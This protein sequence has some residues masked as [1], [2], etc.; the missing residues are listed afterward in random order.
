MA[1][2]AWTGIETRNQIR[3]AS[4]RAVRV[5]ELRGTIAYLDEWL[6]MSA[7]MAASSGERLWAERFEEA[8]PKLDAA[9]AEAA[10]LATP[11]VRAA[12][13]RT[14]DEAHRDLVLM[15]RRALKL[16]A[17]GDLAAARALLGGPEFAYLKDVYASGIEEFGVDL[18]TLAT[19]RAS[20]LNDRAW[21]E[22]AGLGL[23][24]V[25]LVSTAL[26][27]RTQSRLRRAAART[28][29]M[30]RTDA[31]TDLPN[32]RRFYEELEAALA[33]KPA[34]CVGY[35]L[36][37]IDLDR[38][39][40]ANDAYGH[41]AGDELLRLV[42]ARLKTIVRIGDLIARLSGDEFAIVLPLAEDQSQTSNDPAQVA[43]RVLSVL[44]EPFGLGAG[45]LAQIA[46]SV[47][48]A[49]AQPEDDRSGELMHRAEVALY[50]AKADG[51][52]CVRYFEPTMDDHV[53]ARALL[54]SELRQAVADDT[55]VPYF[56][57]LIEIQSGRLIGV[58]MLARWPHPHRGM[59]SPAEF[60]PIAEE[61]GLIGA[62][63][64][65]LLQ[66][67]CR[68]AA[69]WPAH[70]TLACNVSPVQLRDPNLSGM[71]RDILDETGFAPSR[72]VIEVTESALV[73]DLKLA[74]TLLD[75]LKGLGVRL[76]LDDFGTGYSGL[77]HLHLLP[78]DKLKIDASFVG[79]MTD[80]RESRKI[81][82][83][84]VGLGQSLG[85][86]VVAEGVETEETLALLRTLGC[87]IGQ[88]W[89]F[90]RPG[91][92]DRIDAMILE[93]GGAPEVRLAS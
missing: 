63:T 84:V 83:A 19:S 23:I 92:A 35:A 40:A 58:E 76:A 17:D 64:H 14:T 79:A 2:L 60:I 15:E 3:A 74:R 90:G 41:A 54:E 39:R 71:V 11:E 78:F 80:D 69:S 93:A 7:Q 37:L 49:Y 51:R 36:L 10:D 55:I 45:C 18:N 25:L 65:H 70:M 24:A 43:R 66:R 26:T 81:V 85:L 31:L 33:A 20:D 61:L 48:V 6:T 77:R 50:R 62:M 57:P 91:P 86:S 87:D 68:D 82:A 8:A 73:G 9:I 34:G 67:A 47:G 1:W 12:L 22:A 30:A 13:G 52:G 21:M 89:L 16:A 88:G 4:Q 42:A 44:S 56:Q 75:E 27:V 53:R 29:A 32:R 5:A 38:F 28:A 59:V 72:L 46:G